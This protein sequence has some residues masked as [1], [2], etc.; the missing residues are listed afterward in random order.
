[1][2]KGRELHGSAAIPAAVAFL[3]LPF[4][5]MGAAKHAALGAALEYIVNSRANC[6]LL[7]SMRDA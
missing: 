2:G 1:M 3:T 5:G 7:G 6:T 4:G